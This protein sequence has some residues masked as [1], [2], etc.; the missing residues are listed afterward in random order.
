MIG[1]LSGCLRKVISQRTFLG[2]H[3]WKRDFFDSRRIAVD[4]ETIVAS[5]KRRAL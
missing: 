3:A 1:P 5:W 4:S 2:E